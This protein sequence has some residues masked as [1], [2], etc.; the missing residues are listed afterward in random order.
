MCGLTFLF[1]PSLESAELAA[2]TRGS[3]EH[4]QYRGPDGEGVASRGP[5]AIGHRRLAIIDLEA[6]TQPMRD[7][8]GRFLLVYNG[9]LYNYRE[10]RARLE[11]HWAFE[12]NGDTEVI[13]AGLVVKGVPFLQEM[14]GMWA[15]ALWDTHAENL[16]L[17]RD[18]M[19][20][21]P[22]YYR[23]T[24]DGGFACASELPAL[25]ALSPEAWREDLDSTADYFRYG[26]QLPGYT[27][28]QDVFE[29]M[30]GHSLRWTPNSK[31]EQEAYWELSP[32]A[33]AGTQKQAAEQ[34]RETTIEA[35]RK[36]LVADVEVGAFLSGG[37]DSSLVAAIVRKELRAPLKTFTIGF[38]ERSF[39]ER[40]YARRAAEFLATDH[41][42][43]A[44]QE[45]SEKAL[46]DLILDTVGQPFAD[47]SLLPTTLVSRTA[48]RHVK[49]ALSGDGG[50]ELF[51]GYQRYQARM[52]LR[53]Y[54]R[55]PRGLRRNA[56]R[57]IRKLPEPMAHHSRSIL[58]KA[59]LFAD[60]ADRQGAET[61]YYAP[62]LLAPRHFD[63]ITPDLV[64][65]GHPPPRLPESTTHDDL[66][67]MMLAD[68]CIYLPQDILAKVDRASMAHSLEA[69]APFLDTALTELAFSMPRQWHRRGF[70]GKRMLRESFGE[71]L[72]DWLWQRRKQGF[73]V[74]LHDWFRGELGNMLR[75]S[76][77]DDDGPIRREN[78][79]PMLDEHQ[80]RS[81]DHGNRLWLIYVYQLWR[82]NL[83]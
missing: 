73:G 52:L 67:R 41:H 70:S 49:V 64:E 21:K 48:S 15:L 30:P 23:Q 42:E 5:W 14:E 22:L 66:Q 33:F 27:S 59:H 34:L 4:L 6:S 74:P 31:P 55:L 80:R 79:L 56:H 40:E 72:P 37:V 29:V 63:A 58:K 60:A 7:A 17:S 18:R 3:L 25:K 69:R 1:N 43:E 32:C 28:Y 12:T 65:H 68:A 10:L 35:V 81:R 20:E 26:F 50:D 39:D 57:A 82:R 51:S 13:L 38:R 54:T 24:P 16:L 75:D 11:P 45:F 62:L 53:W 76:V 47:P 78:L 44:L 46:E 71:L 61:P 83:A 19:G 77:S 36:R 9:E 2:R 8:S